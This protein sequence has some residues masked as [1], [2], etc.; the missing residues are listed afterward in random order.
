MGTYELYW[1]LQATGD[2]RLLSKFSRHQSEQLRQAVA[3]N[4]ATPAPILYTLALDEN[5]DVRA[6]VAGNSS[7]PEDLLP[8][9][10]EDPVPSVGR[11]MARN[12]N[13]PAAKF[14]EW[15]GRD[16]HTDV[17]LA[18]NPACPEDVMLQLIALHP[19]TD[20]TVDL[21]SNPSATLR[22][23]EV[24]AN[25]EHEGARAVLATNV[26]LPL[27][28]LL[29][30]LRDPDEQVRTNA[31]DHWNCPVQFL[32]AAAATKDFDVWAALARNP[33]TPVSVLTELGSYKFLPHEYSRPEDS[34]ANLWVE[35]YVEVLEALA[36]NPALPAEL[37]A[38]LGDS[39]DEKVSSKAHANPAWE[40]Y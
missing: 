40:S 30:L 5:P 26:M 14:R 2:V 25:S 13:L 29:K 34:P 23:L 7:C 11:T 35:T 37:L 36:S 21:A 9:L 39:D 6:N 38:R 15:V 33:R 10:L 22:V 18:Q 4:S 19:Q 31:R 20:P 28:L 17:F 24:I 3:L 32:E 1:H 8:L 16:R 27:P 12:P